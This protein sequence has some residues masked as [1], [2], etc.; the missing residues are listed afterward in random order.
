MKM[1]AVIGLRGMQTD[2]NFELATNVTDAGEFNDIVCTTNGRRY[3]LKLEHTENP[4]NDKFKPQQ[5][6]KLLHECFE[7]Y[8]NIQDRDKSEFLIYT[9]KRLGSTLS[10]HKLNMVVI[11][12]V[13]KIFKTSDNGKIF[14]FT[15]CKNEKIDVYSGVEKYVKVNKGFRKLSASEKKCKVSMVTEFLEKLIM[16]T[17]QNGEVEELDDVIIK[18]IKE[19]DAIKVGDEMYKREL[20]PFKDY[21]QTWWWWNRNEKITT[22][23]LK[24]W[25]QEA[26]TA[27]CS[28]LVSS[29]FDSCK[30]NLAETGD[31]FTDNEISILQAE[32]YNKNAVHLTSDAL[33]LCSKLLL[34]CL[35][36]SKCNFV[37]FASLQSNINMLLHAWLGG[38]WEWLI[39][40]CDST[41]QQSDISDTCLKMSEDI[42]HDLSSKRVIIL[43]EY[44]VQQITGFFPIDH[45]FNSEPRSDESDAMGLDK[46]MSNLKL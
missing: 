36:Q 23:I 6:F 41:V 17:G 35:P 3:C 7:S 42:K 19:Q 37:T 13:E 14:N 24:T 26:K 44:S 31:K 4:E 33:T 1:A 30:T 11:D 28:S 38:H 20:H 15:R 18:E 10:K 29:L 27:C 12:T 5:M 22:Q 43:T 25:L 16:V 45:R 40:Y 9:N 34:D 32:L 39:V 21:L 46:K 8:Y 2:D